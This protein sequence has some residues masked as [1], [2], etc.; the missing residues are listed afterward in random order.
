MLLADEP[1][2]VN[3]IHRGRVANIRPFGVFISIPG[4]RRDVLVHHTQVGGGQQ[5]LDSV[6]L[7]P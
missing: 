6:F 4:Y 5:A 2:P 3:S 1:P 7:R